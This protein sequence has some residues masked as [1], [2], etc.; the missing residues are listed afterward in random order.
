MS[1]ELSIKGTDYLMLSEP[2]RVGAILEANLGGERLRPGD[3]DT[4]KIPTGGMTQWAVDG[5]EGQSFVPALTGIVVHMHNQRAYYQGEYA[6]GN[7]KPDCSSNDGH[8]PYG[9][10]GDEL[11][12]AGKSCDDCPLSQFGSGKNGGQACRQSRRVYLVRPGSLLP[13]VL[14]LSPTS[15]ANI[16]KYLLRL[17]TTP[18]WSVVTKFSL[19]QAVNK[20]GIKYAV[21]IPES[22]GKLDDAQVSHVENFREALIES[23]RYVPQQDSVDEAVEF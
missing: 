6:G 19:K 9:N 11:R 14:T 20:S 15:L 22:V 13:I 21:A 10:P 12:L 4:V 17:G 18:Y 1:T 3:L 7:E 5:P 2:D 8:T 16:R 23:M